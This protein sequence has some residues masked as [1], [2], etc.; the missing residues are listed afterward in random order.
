VYIG[1]PFL[2]DY[3]FFWEVRKGD[4][5]KKLARP[6]TAIKR[7]TTSDPEQQTTNARTVIKIPG[8]QRAWRLIVSSP[9]N[10]NEHYHAKNLHTKYLQM[11]NGEP[12]DV[13]VGENGTG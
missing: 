9:G 4:K 7:N 5:E 11:D 13:T 8:D 10:L 6:I 1:L 3:E 12:D 2:A